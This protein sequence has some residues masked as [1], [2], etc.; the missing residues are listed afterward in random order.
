MKKSLILKSIFL[1]FATSLILISC[2]PEENIEE[3]TIETEEIPEEFESVMALTINNITENYDAYAAYCY[4]AETG[5]EWIQI[6]NNSVWL[7]TLVGAP[8]I[9]LNDFVIYHVTNEGQIGSFAMAVIQGESFG[10]TAN[11]LVFN[12]ADVIIDEVNETYIKGSMKGTFAF[13]NNSVDFDVEF[14][15]EIIQASDTCN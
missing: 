12:E 10:M 5:N 14:A 13:Q 1:M 3:I 6:T 4:N 2:A 7:D 9:A 11:V 8:D 15:A